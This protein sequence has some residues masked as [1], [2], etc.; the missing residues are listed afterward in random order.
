[1]TETWRKILPGWY[2]NAPLRGEL[3]SGGFSDDYE[4]WSEMVGN[5]EHEIRRVC[6]DD[7]V[8]NFPVGT[9]ALVIGG[10]LDCDPFATLADA[11][12]YA[13]QSIRER[14]DR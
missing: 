4:N 3:G 10:S 1:M 2:T 12:A 9:W 7:R 13:E 8:G 14:A 6:R 11:K 5:V